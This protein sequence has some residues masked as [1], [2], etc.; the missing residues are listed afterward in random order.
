MN[1]AIGL[2]EIAQISRG[3]SI[4]DA[5]AK[6]APV[7]IERATTVSH[8]KFYVLFS[9]DEES[10][11]E[12]LAAGEQIAGDTLADSL[13][14][15]YVHEQLRAALRGK[16]H[17]A[18]LASFAAIESSTLAGTIY[19]ADLAL[20]IAEVSLI[21]L[22]LGQGIG[23]RGFFTLSGELY[24]IEAAVSAAK[25]HLLRAGAFVGADIIAAPHDDV[26]SILLR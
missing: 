18:D 9:G 6:K 16:R 22:Q 26:H 24:D 11:R 2:I 20:K 21:E 15:P 13:F 7:V 17:K 19:C 3:F 14:I 23:G 25:E 12:S 10:V 8:G 1:H 5:L 4:C